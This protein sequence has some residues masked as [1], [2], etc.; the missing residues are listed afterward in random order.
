MVQ[1]QTGRQC[2]FGSLP[3]CVPSRTAARTS[4]DGP[5]PN[6]APMPF[7]E[8]P[9]LCPEQ[10]GSKNEWGWSKSKLGANAIL[11]VSL[12]VSRAGAAAKSV[13]LYQHIANLAGNKDIVLP[14]P[15]FN[16]INGGSHAGN[17]LP[18]QEFML[19][20]TGAKDFREAMKIGSET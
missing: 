10:D 12:A 9:S 5:N 6:W 15:S 2:H 17:A 14:V 13:P 1:I 19:L 8:S 18:V 11:G 4:G 3:R 7:W 16:I 20:P